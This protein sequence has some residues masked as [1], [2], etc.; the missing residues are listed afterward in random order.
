MVG[1][2]KPIGTDRFH[3]TCAK[4]LGR[5]RGTSGPAT[6]DAATGAP[7]G[8]AFPVI[9][10]TDMV[11]AQAML[12]DHPDIARLHA[13]DGG[14]MG[15]MQTL[16]WAATYPERLQSALVIESA[17]RHSVQNIA[18]HEVGRQSILADPDRQDGQYYGSARAPT[19]GRSEE[20]TSELK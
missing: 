3:V 1:P 13:V 10:I 19:Q 7:L 8:M 6:P 2:G 14:S 15:G 16:A 18:F 9:T 5:C 17:A 20:H 4:V 11:R 12:L